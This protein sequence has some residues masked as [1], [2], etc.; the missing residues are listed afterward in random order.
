M[1]YT[2]RAQMFSARSMAE[3]RRQNADVLEK[4]QD[5]SSYLEERSG[6]MPIIVEYKEIYP[7]ISSTETIPPNPCITTVAQVFTALESMMVY[8]AARS[9]PPTKSAREYYLWSF[10]VASAYSWVTS[11]Q[12]I[13][14]TK[15]SWNWDT[16]NIVDS[17]ND[18]FVWMT[19]VLVG[20]MSNFVPSFDTS[21][22]LHNETMNFNWTGQEQTDQW[23]RVSA[24]GN[25]SAWLSAWNTWYTNRGNDGNIAASVAPSDSVLPNG[26]TRLN[27]S[28][29]QNISAYPSPQQWT[30]LIVNGAVKNFLTYGWGDVT[31]TCLSAPNETTIKNTASTYFLGTT[32]ARDTEMDDLK[33]VTS[34][35][36]DA[37][38]VGAEFWAGGPTTVSPPC[39]MLW[40]W[41]KYIELTG[42]GMN[43]MVYSGLEL[44]INIFESSRLTWALKRDKMEDRP[45]QEFRR[46]YA[47]ET[48]TKYDGT[49][50]S[51]SLWVPY[52]ETNFVTPPFAD[53]PS[54]HSTFS[55]SFANVMSAW[56]GNTIPTND[57]VMSDLNLLSP[58]F[59]GT[60]VNKLTNITVPARSSRIE[61]TVPATDINMTWT[62]WQEIADSAGVSR[63]YGGIHCVS[64]NLGGQSVANSI[65]PLVHSNWAISRG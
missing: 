42:Y 43:T 36:T 56:F 51:G 28:I 34:S 39:M 64:A 21:T 55:Q 62:T 9:F 17:D 49:S 47:A 22:L 30:P 50:I 35:L 15:D 14:G 38:K 11:S 32:P 25:Y 65:F 26:S 63:Q 59:S 5:F 6:P 41:K 31:S 48:L 10:T 23:A 33:T 52:Q 4:T 3:F 8:N 37:Q 20:V 53:F 27:V 60:Y 1:D 44:S 7:L 54:G 29:S 61:D 2:R 45:I 46:R 57:I 16:K 13:S 24:K 19:H 58:I 18:V 40:F 12:Y